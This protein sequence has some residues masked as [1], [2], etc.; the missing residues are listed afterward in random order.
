M[1]AQYV[2]SALDRASLLWLLSAFVRHT[3]SSDL[4]VVSVSCGVG[5]FKIARNRQ[6]RGIVPIFV[7]VCFFYLCSACD[8]QNKKNRVF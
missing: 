1:I 2:G 4:T 8:P 6:L 5:L 3:G 7:Q